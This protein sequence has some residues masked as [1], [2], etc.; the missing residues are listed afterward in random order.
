MKRNVYFLI[1]MMLMIISVC[2]AYSQEQAL[3]A[4][5]N[6]SWKPG[7]GFEYFSR[8]IEW[9]G[10]QSTSKLKSYYFTFNA[11]I[12]LQSGLTLSGLIGYSFSSY[13]YLIFKELPFSLDLQ[14]GSIGGFILGAGLK[15]NLFSFSDIEIGAYGQFV[16]CL[17]VKKNWEIPGLA[18]EG[19][20]QGKPSWMRGAAGPIFSYEGYDYFQPYLRLN[21]NKLWG[22]FNME[23]TVEDLSGEEKKK[24]TGKSLLE[25]SL[26]AVYQLSNSISFQAEI[27]LL[28]YNGGVDLGMVIKGLYSF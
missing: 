6:I 27:N 13:N 9:N 8:T 25:A 15:K 7:F 24:I 14:P 11:D 23:E 21:F 19:T 18:V 2:F 5:S 16:Y 20:A 28:P 3:P 10:Q 1:F 12:E 4:E 26:G 22:T 17:G